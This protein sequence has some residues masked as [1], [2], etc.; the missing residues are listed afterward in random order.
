MSITC[1]SLTF[2]EEVL[3]QIWAKKMKELLLEMKA[4]VEQAK[5]T[6]QH[7]LEIPVLARF[8]HRYDELLLEGYLANPGPPPRKSEQSK[9]KPGKAKQSPSR[10]VSDRLSSEEAGGTPLPARFRCSFLANN[11]AERDLEDD[12]NPAKSL[13]GLPH[14]TRNCHV[15]SHS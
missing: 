13:G 7:E 5:A 6:G 2:V 11:Q 9:R 8:L 14:R 10:N 3:K 1:V 15:L 4:E 12:Q